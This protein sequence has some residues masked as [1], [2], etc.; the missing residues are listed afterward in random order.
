MSHWML[1][2]LG[3]MRDKAL[4]EAVRAQVLS[5]LTNLSHEI[6]YALIERIAQALETVVMDLLLTPATET[7]QLRTLRK[8]AADAYRLYRVLP[9]QQNTLSEA[10]LRLRQSALAVLGDLGAD[11]ARNLR[12]KEWPTLE[13]ESEEWRTRTLSTIIDIWLR[14]IRKQGWDDRDAVLERIK[15]LRQSQ[16]TFESS[17]LKNVEGYGAKAAALELMALYHLAKAA[18]ILALY[19]T[20]GVVDGSFQIKNLLDM[21]FDRAVA[22]CERGT[23]MQLEPLIRL[24]AATAR[25]LAD[26]AIWTVTRAVNSRVTKF[27]RSLVDRGRGD[28]ALFDVLPPQRRALA[29]QGLLGSS[30]RAVVVSLPTS[31]GKTLIAQFRIL[32]ALNQ[33]D[34]EAMQF[35]PGE[36]MTDEPLFKSTH[37][38]LVFAFQYAGQQSPKTP[39][40]SL[41]RTPGLGSGKGLSGVDGA[42]QAGMILAEVDRLPDDQHNVI[43]ARYGHVLHECPCCEQDAPSDEW[44]LAID[45]LSRC[46]ELEGVHRKVRLMM[47][48]RAICGGRL[49]IDLLCRRYSLARSTTFKQLAVI[50]AKL[51]KIEK[52]ALSNLDSAFFEKKELVA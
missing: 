37:D 23:A 16:G 22:A 35:I 6:D 43:V 27:V 32:Q 12:E 24:L 15:M 48:E 40:T 44:R 31:S 20:D 42:A 50:K 4:H 14:M 21:H 45:A 1:E 34:H 39:L 19:V 2:S 51:R 36:K 28:K 17:Y 26:N 49:D 18:E 10:E 13:L 3:E 11:A 5:E 7:D 29:E 52:I 33:F 25:Q 8:C 38:A 41:L 47:V 30:R 9:E 46:V